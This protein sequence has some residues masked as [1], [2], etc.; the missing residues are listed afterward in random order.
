MIEQLRRF[1]TAISFAVLA[2][3]A[4]VP[5]LTSSPGRMPADSKLYVYLNPGRFLTDTTT[6][7][8]PRQ[9][10]GWVPHQHIAYLWPTG[11]WFWFFETLGVPDW[12][13]H[14][15]WIG[16]LLL[17]AGAGMRSLARVLGIAP[18]AALVAA[19]VYQ[20]SPYV[21]PYISRT[22][23][24]LLPWAGLG[25]IVAFTVL[26]TRRPGWRY[27]A[28]IALVVF[29]VGAVNATALAMVIPAPALWL[30]HSLWG[31]TI[32]WRATVAIAARTGAL[33]TG[34]SLWWIVMLMI[35]GRNGADVLAF[36]ESLEAVSF[37]STS[38]EV[39]R[40]LGYWLFYVR[41]AYAAT[42]TA[43]LDHLV[44]GRTVLAG[45][46]VTLTGFAGIA[47]G[48]WEHRRFA[49]LLVGAGIVL[50]VGVHPIDDPSP[51][52]SLLV[53]DGEGGLALALRSSTRAVPVLLIGLAL[54]A[55]HVVTAV[56]VPGRIDPRRLRLATAGAIA[57]VAVV[58]LPALRNGGF[59]DEAL[60]RDQDP[61]A[62]WLAAAADLDDRPEGYRVL[63]VPGTEF[64]A[65][66]WGYTVDQPLPAL[67]ERPLITRDLLP[68]G[69]PAAMDLVFALD[70]R[71][72]TDTIE[73]VAVEAVARLL[74]V[75]TVWI[76][77][78]VAYDRFR[79]ARPE[80]VLD[81]LS[82]LSSTAFGDPVVM[83]SAIS[84]VDNRQLADPRLGQPIPPVTLAEVV[85]P[86]PTERVKDT[87]VVLAG[88]GDG[89]ID[90][91]AAG[92]ID[93]TELILYAGSID[94]D[95]GLSNAYRLVIT[96]SNRDRAHH[97]RS[98]QDVSG[99]TE[100]AADGSD[101]LRFES[102]DQRLAVFDTDE[103]DQQSV[104]I[105]DGPVSAQASSYGE[106]FAYLPEHR[107]VMA[108]D[109]DPDTAWIV[110][111]R[112]PAVGEFI[113]LDFDQAIDHLELLQPPAAPDQRTI[114]QVSVAADGRP[115]IAFDLDERS[116]SASGQR[117]DID[118][119]TT[120]TI[121]ITATTAP[122]PPIG[123]AIGGVGFAE[124]R[125]GLEPTTEIIRTP[126]APSAQ[127]GDADGI[128][129]VLTRLRVEPLDR[130][131]DDP[132]PVLARQF[133]LA[134]D[135]R[136]VP[137]VTLRVDQRL[138]S[139]GLAQLL[140]ENVTATGHLA[141]AP[142]RRGAAAFD[143]RD[144]TAWVTPFDDVTG[145]SVTL[146]GDGVASTLNIAQPGGDAF[147]P[148]TMLRVTDAQGAF[149]LPIQQG[150][151]ITVALPRSVDLQS[152]TIEIIDIDAVFVQNRRFNEPTVL[153]AA[154]S[155]ILFDGRSPAVTAT[156]RL[157]A[158][159]RDDLLSIDEVGVPLSFDVASADA[160]AGEPIDVTLCDPELTLD[161]GTHRVISANGAGT[162][163]DVDRV[164]LSTPAS[165]SAAP[166]AVDPTA[167]ITT[168]SSRRS[169]TLVIPACPT[170]CWVVH[171][172]GYNEAWRAQIDGADL[173]TPTLV[174]GN[175]NGWW[176]EPSNEPA[177]VEITWPVQRR[178]NTALLLSLLAVAACVG[179]ATWRRSPAVAPDPAVVAETVKRL[180]HLDRTWVL[181]GVAAIAGALLIDW[182]WAV[183]VA[184]V[185][186][187]A[188]LAK[189]PSIVAWVGVAILTG[190]AAVVTAVVRN[191]TPF[192]DAGW[193]V[194]FDWL[195]PIT[196]VG[197]VLLVTG[198]C[199][200]PDATSG[201]RA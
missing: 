160:L 35:Q 64:G 26:A 28:A 180:P 147:S 133:E 131:R 141:G 61:P 47:L 173:G 87:V 199:V 66:Q 50:G 21:L 96:D 74:G 69:S 143:G 51:L 108:I 38:T 120:A 134:A 117:I 172:E 85:D 4:Y 43:S 3:L 138:S 157:S 188:V 79:L 192:P 148:I 126:L 165:G 16:T 68:L 197:V 159:C 89:I 102:G 179:L 166:G 48:R 56:R 98:S 112:A 5:S 19:I 182:M 132:E 181:A 151:D 146:E 90:A 110:A 123:D 116:R 6:S 52:M 168:A 174:D 130:W 83:G 20:L 109:G 171:G 2:L 124:I 99:F 161:A 101:V 185:W 9:F 155:E 11:P 149:D 125:T 137:S 140:D 75:D 200:R 145:Q 100:S 176:I 42:T 187:L 80:V 76:T 1:Q 33:C 46:L 194:R 121:A 49:A 29:T 144:E 105:Q 178:L 193:P 53:G 32:S 113:R 167:A 30:V 183:P 190:S 118:V 7:F 17:A 186:A 191:D 71:F 107:P 156:E 142:N 31:R 154:I 195:H 169:R 39:T 104:S 92:V 12:V 97:W 40:G 41:D 94:D 170:G 95:A 196:L 72:Q 82:G 122:Q 175:A 81:E 65:F 25:W 128:D 177:T 103:A 37:T 63:Q 15:L 91:A 119:T 158:V 13:A 164:V 36:S 54:G 184:V 201:Q 73:P 129:V 14:R 115:P 44:S 153:P 62:A 114:S 88:S 34:V 67:T 18:L 189:R 8:D 139:V 78:D 58:A 57:A 70:D 45:W 77:G 162:G 27:P 55:A 163:F 60:E 59:V 198:A 127:H 135:G 22:S 24:L 106:R 111:D 150:T 86:I 23:V 10:A 136:F 84:M 93:G 152:I